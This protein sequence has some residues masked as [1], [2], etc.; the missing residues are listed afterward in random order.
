[1]DFACSRWK[2]T[3]TPRFGSNAVDEA[4]TRSFV[5][6]NSVED[7]RGTES[8]EE[9]Q[10]YLGQKHQ[11][12]GETPEGRP[13]KQLEDSRGRKILVNFITYQQLNPPGATSTSTFSWRVHVLR[14]MFDRLYV[15][16]FTIFCAYPDIRSI[17]RHSQLHIK[18]NQNKT[19]TGNL[20]NTLLYASYACFVF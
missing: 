8:C 18:H 9:G 19:S 5:G 4:C 12:D 6:Q 10:N 17:R 13:H 2:L 20:L 7:P 15:A 14:D 11:F 16:S 1:M 3:L